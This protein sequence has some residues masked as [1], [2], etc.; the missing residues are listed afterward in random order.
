M[1]RAGGSIIQAIDE[2]NTGERGLR[3]FQ[4]MSDDGPDVPAPGTSLLDPLE[5]LSLFRRRKD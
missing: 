5:P 3:A 2:L 4:A 1:T